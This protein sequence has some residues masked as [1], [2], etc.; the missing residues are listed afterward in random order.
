MTESR[1][2]TKGF[3]VVLPGEIIEIAQDDDISWL[4]LFYALPKELAEKYPDALKIPR[5][6]YEVLYE[7][8][9]GAVAKSDML[10]MLVW[11]CYSWAAWQFFKVKDRKGNYREIPGSR[12]HYAGFFPLWRLSYAIIPYIRMK[13][14]KCGL[15]FQ[16]LYN[17]P[18]G[19]EV[20]WLTYQQFGNL[21]GNLTDMIVVEQQ[22]QPVID[23][24]WEMR[25]PEDY[26]DK[27]SVPKNDYMRKWHHNRSGKSISIDMMMETEDGAVFAIADPRAEFEKDIMDENQIEAFKNSTL[28]DKDQEILRLRMLGH[29][30]QE[31]ADKVG[32]KTAS[33]VHKRI[34]KIASIY[35][36]FV[37]GEYQKYL[38]KPIK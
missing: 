22:W 5:C 9:Y 11:D 3:I 16:N 17:M 8:S 23:A 20:P 37:T 25:S 36:D 4:T 21:V 2:G 32:Y 18:R 29:T 13:F 34:A 30:E 6:P 1:N 35:E 7:G 33:A 14:E 38:D 15:G 31:I 19:V 12:S 10:K 26:D 27:F 28:T 24:A